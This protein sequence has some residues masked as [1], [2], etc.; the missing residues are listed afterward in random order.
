MPP[1]AVGILGIATGIV[2]EVYASLSHVTFR[3]ILSKNALTS[4][5]IF[6][7]LWDPLAVVKQISQARLLVI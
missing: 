6:W 4:C 3:D 2:D 1:G 7:V 5:L